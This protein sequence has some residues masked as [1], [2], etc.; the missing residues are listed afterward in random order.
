M[1]IFLYRMEMG[2]EPEVQIAAHVFREL[3]YNHRDSLSAG[4]IVAGWD[5]NYGGQVRIEEF[6][7]KKPVPFIKVQ[8]ICPVPC[9]MDISPWYIVLWKKSFFFL[10]LLS[11]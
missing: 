10:L 2:D 7:F 1:L 11:E 4:I 3:C 5:K 9:F 6:D 8:D